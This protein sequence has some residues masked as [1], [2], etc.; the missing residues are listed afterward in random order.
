[1]SLIHCWLRP[2]RRTPIALRPARRWIPYSP[3]QVAAHRAARRA[4]RAAQ[5]VCVLVPFVIAGGGVAAIGG[6]GS[7]HHDTFAPPADTHAVNVFEPSTS[8]MFLAA[9]GLLVVLRRRFR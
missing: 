1:M 3:A 7:T 9:V 4:R 2:A 6:I 5:V 8:L